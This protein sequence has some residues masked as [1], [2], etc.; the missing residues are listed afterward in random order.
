[1]YAR[2]RRASSGRL[3]SCR[4]WA[5]LS[6]QRLA[7]SCDRPALR[8]QTSSHID[9]ASA[10]PQGRAGFIDA[11]VTGPPNRASSATVPPMAMAAPLSTARPSVATAMITNVK[12]RGEDELV[13]DRFCG[14]DAHRS[15]I[16]TSRAVATT[17]SCIPIHRSAATTGLGSSTSPRGRSSR[18]STGEQGGGPTI[19]VPHGRAP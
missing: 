14:P 6:E 10:G 18:T 9:E 3:G 17:G 8:R 1:M 12:R 4:P 13:D 7:P 11:P 19:P 16:P 2:A 15:P 5:R